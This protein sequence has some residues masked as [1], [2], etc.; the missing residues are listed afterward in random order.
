MKRGRS[1]KGVVVRKRF[2]LPRLNPEI[3]ADRVVLRADRMLPPFIRRHVSDH[4]LVGEYLPI[5]HRFFSSST[6]IVNFHCV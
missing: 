2:V 6:S 5:L 3:R 1:L 4:A